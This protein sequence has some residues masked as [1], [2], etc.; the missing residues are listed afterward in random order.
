MADNTLDVSTANEILNNAPTGIFSTNEKGNI[1]WTN[2]T[3]VNFFGDISEII[4]APAERLF[5]QILEPSEE[6][7]ELFHLAPAPGR[8]QR[9]LLSAKQDVSS[10]PGQVWYLLDVTEIMR[11]QVEVNS[12][13]QQLENNSPTDPLTGL[14]NAKALHNAMDRQVSRSRR[15]GNPLAIMVIRIENFSSN[16]GKVSEDQILK[17]MSF[18]LRDQLRWVDLVGRTGEKEFTLVL[19]ETHAEDAQR[20]AQKIDENVQQLNI[21]DENESI[22]NIKVLAG[23]TE[24]R[25]GDDSRVIL[26]R[27]NKALDQALKGPE[28]LQS[29]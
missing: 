6:S 17:G 21:L 29:C 4:N 27:I 10:G 25:K 28:N 23:M 5:Q 24:W 14:L 9:W 22:A 8:Q 20:L 16:S 11:L 12:L 7:P 2:Q 3:L 19:P 15:Y 26:K 1:V 13:S 18:Y